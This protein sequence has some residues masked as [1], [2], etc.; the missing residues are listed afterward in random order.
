VAEG[1][2][3]SLSNIWGTGELNGSQKG[4]GGRER[5]RQQWDESRGRMTLSPGAGSIGKCGLMMRRT[6]AHK[7][8]GPRHDL[9]ERE[10]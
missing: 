1:G 3:E 10:W 5:A 8:P 6:S 4:C 7:A 2:S 9:F